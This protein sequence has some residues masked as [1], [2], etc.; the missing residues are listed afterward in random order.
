MRLLLKREL[1]NSKICKIC[2]K[3]LAKLSR[4]RRTMT[5]QITRRNKMAREYGKALTKEMLQEWGIEE[6]Y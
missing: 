2:Q 1:N 5:H 4:E 3:I 6:I